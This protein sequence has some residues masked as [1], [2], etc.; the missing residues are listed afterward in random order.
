MRKGTKRVCALALGLVLATAP[1]TI[2]ACT[3]GGNNKDPL[4]DSYEVTYKLNYEGA[5]ER[6]VEVATGANAVSWRPY[7][8][9][10]FVN[11]WYTDQ[12][13]TQEFDFT[14]RIG[15]DITLYALW[16]KEAENHL[17][18]FNGNSKSSVV[19]Q[20]AVV[21]HGEKLEEK[22][23]PEMT[24]KGFVLE[25]WYREPECQTKWDVETDTVTENTTLYANYVYDSTI[26]RDENGK[27]IFN[28]VTVNVWLSGQCQ[29]NEGVI[30]SLAE[31]FNQEYEGKI[32]VNATSN[33]FSQ[34]LFSLRFQ[35]NPSRNTST[36]YWPAS[37]IYDMAGIEYDYADWY[38]DALGDSL[39][40]GKLYSIPFAA[41]VPYIVYNK[42]LMTKYNG[43]SPLPSNYAEF[44][45]LLK[46]VYEGESETNSAFKSF[47][48]NNSWTYKE[49]TSYAAFAQNGVE[50]YSFENG[51][52]INNW[53]D[54]GLLQKAT[55]AFE[56]TYAMLS[57]GGANHGGF[58]GNSYNDS[59]V[60]S[61]VKNG[62]A[63][64]GIVNWYELTATN[65]SS[66]GKTID[67][68]PLSG[69]FGDA[70]SEFK[71]RIPVHTLG[72][73]FCNY[74]TVLTNTEIAAAAVFADY[75][76]KNSIGVVGNCW[77][78]MRKSV[79]ES[80]EFQKPK[81]TSSLKAPLDI[82]KKVGDPSNF[83][84]L[85]GHVNGK[86]IFNSLVAEQYILPFIAGDGK[87]AD[88]VAKELMLMLL[89]EITR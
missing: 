3:T 77:Y 78:P 17:V 63:L 15:K 13:C 50:Y 58:A 23:F 10:Y 14:K 51:N 49:A 46:K 12:A 79:V 30:S 20:S 43:D 34:G 48:T 2:T 57:E 65:A 52:Y 9:G 56:R 80:N 81:S 89:G 6:K 76:S 36:S 87:D 86:N 4:Q 24:K 5:G 11:G 64:M 38:E 71:D 62:N 72:M 41:S 55:T 85:T 42:N 31:K 16:A 21:K 45:A 29:G 47:V 7:R 70:D 1:M 27:P 32:H 53:E 83:Y 84:T 33:L 8:E 82:M 22:Q 18:T 39:V 88:K 19:T 75:V 66:F 25:G 67:I 68:M 73:A 60:F 61:L 44:S 54:D 59:S 26:E 35:Q 69:L 37:D 40:D 74:E 28:N